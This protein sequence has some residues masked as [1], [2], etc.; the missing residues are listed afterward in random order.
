MRI[1]LYQ[2]L[3]S[4]EEQVKILDKMRRGFECKQNLKKCDEMV[5][6]SLLS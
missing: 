4:Q 1:K 3:N 6:S 2:R 5:A